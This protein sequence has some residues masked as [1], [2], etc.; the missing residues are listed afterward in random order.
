MCMHNYA[1]ES[2]YISIAMHVSV[3]TQI[4]WPC[5]YMYTYANMQNNGHPRIFTYRCVCTSL[6][7][8]IQST[9]SSSK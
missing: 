7:I 2:L 6:N 9:K 3:H 4:M 5:A 8:F 1:H